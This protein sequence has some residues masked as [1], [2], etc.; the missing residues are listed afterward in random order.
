LKPSGKQHGTAVAALIAGAPGTRAPGLLPGARIV[1]VD[2][3]HQGGNA[4]DR[5]DI[6]DLVR[7][8]DL[9]VSRSPDAINLS[10]AGPPNL[11]LEQS[12]AAAVNAGIPVIAAV[13]NDGPRARPSY[14]AGY[15]GVIAVTALDRKLAVYRRAGQGEHVDFAAPGVGVWTAASMKGVRRSSGTSFAA[16]FVTAAAALI[17]AADPGIGV[18]ELQSRLA[19]MTLDL[20]RKGHDT[21]FGAGLI[22]GAPACNRTNP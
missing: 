10:L 6:Y 13:G 9:L 8:V 7:A 3:F 14:P 21:T 15:Q 11:L 5:V 22:R 1:A 4:D 17:K 16:P 12:V 2:P 19:G 18:D 20:G